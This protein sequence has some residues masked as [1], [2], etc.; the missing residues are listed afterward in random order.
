MNTYA[1][2][3]LDLWAENGVIVQAKYFVAANSGK[4]IVETEGVWTFAE[5]SAKVLF[6]QVTEE[7][8]IGWIKAEAVRDGQSMIEKRLDE[9]LTTLDNQTKVVAPWLPQVFTPEL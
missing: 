7:M 6:E 3:I 8:V 2:K 1:W 5:P 9:Q 4:N